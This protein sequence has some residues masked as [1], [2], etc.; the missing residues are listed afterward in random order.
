MKNFINIIIIAYFKINWIIPIFLL[1]STNAYSQNYSYFQYTTEQGLPSDYIYGVLEDDKGHIWA[2]TEVGIAKFDGYDWKTFT[3][4]DGLPNDDIVWAIKDSVGA[5]YLWSHPNGL[6]VIYNDTIYTPQGNLKTGILSY[7]NKGPLFI[8]N[9]KILKFDH[10]TLDFI[11]KTNNIE[12]S[13]SIPNTEYK[14][15]KT[16]V[17]HINNG[18]TINKIPIKQF[19]N[20]IILDDTEVVIQRDEKS[21]SIYNPKSKNLIEKSLDQ[22]LNGENKLLINHQINRFFF[23]TNI[24]FVE[25]N[26]NL[27]VI[28]RFESKE[29]A[30]RFEINRCSRD[31]KGNIWIATR[32]DGLIFIPKKKQESEIITTDVLGN[33][34]IEGLA[35]D[36]DNNVFAASDDGKLYELQDEEIKLI[37]RSKKKSNLITLRFDNYYKSIIMD[38]YGKSVILK[39][40]KNNKY[41]FSNLYKIFPYNVLIDKKNHNQIKSNFSD[42]KENN[43][44]T[45]IN[46]ELY[47]V[48]M[49][50]ESIRKI[51]KLYYSKIFPLQEGGIIFQKNDYVF[52][53]NHGKVIDSTYIP[54]DKTINTIYSITKNNFLIGTKNNGLFKW[55][56]LSNRF[57]N[58]FESKVVKKIIRH[59]NNYYI[60][61]Y[62]GIYVLDN[63]YNII[64]HLTTND[65]IP[66]NEIYDI[67][68]HNQH[69]LAATSRG[70]SKTPLKVKNKIS[71]DTTLIKITKINVNGNE[72]DINLLNNLTVQDKNIDIHFNLIHFP[73]NGKI[74]YQYRLLPVQK[75]W[76]TTNTQKVSFYQLAPNIYTFEIR[77]V[78]IYGDIH[79]GESIK[80]T[81]PIALWK[82]IE[83]WIFITLLTIVFLYWLLDKMHKKKLKKQEQKIA[84]NI[85]MAELELTALRSQMNPHFVFNALGSIQYYIQTHKV[86]EADSY[87]TSFALLMRKYLDSSKMNT[88]TI[89]DEVSLL[90]LYTELEQMRFEN[91]FKVEIIVAKSIDQMMIPTMLLQPFVENAILHGLPIRTNNDGLIKIIFKEE[92]QKV[93]V[94]IIDNGIGFQQNNKKNKIHKSHG[95]SIIND[96]IDTLEKAGKVKINLTIKNAYDNK[97]YPGTKVTLSIQL[98]PFL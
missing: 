89:K 97:T 15:D 55:D 1:I 21:I 19:R 83:F 59:R 77:A 93:I 43:I 73:S 98:I 79:H 52:R 72:T 86:D 5:I 47:Y 95:L 84:L 65:G 6:S 42:N 39:K 28:D 12:K 74:E 69:I 31:S 94:N 87:L 23:S 45:D 35:I 25:I 58:I 67:V 91:K 51:A 53:I 41:Q 76:A 48:D 38:N 37:Y 50:T 33:S 54:N 46:R 36:L 70:I 24:G 61:T 10:L 2:Y 32:S 80:F 92:N 3:S 40:N 13:S 34:V 62:S 29:M 18:Q 49:N 64:R 4:K 82:R 30:N 63:D 90:K 56:I 9:N 68:I 60:S 71:K 44:Y 96:K 7:Q 78:D 57:D 14:I 81:I 8:N 16:H 11:V 26:N 88:I 66:S 20:T 27:E 17:I 85:K 22:I 75:N